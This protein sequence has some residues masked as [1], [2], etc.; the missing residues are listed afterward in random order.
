MS[1]RH[2]PAAHGTRC[3]R[4]AAGPFRRSRSSTYAWYYRPTVRRS[5]IRRFPSSRRPMRAAAVVLFVTAALAPLRAGAQAAWPD[6]PA[7]RQLAGWVAAFN[8]SSVDS[9][10]RFLADHAPGAPTDQPMLQVSPGTAGF[11]AQ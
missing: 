1:G 8:A 2:G 5:T 10:R 4:W 6:T 11:R 9:L 3:G 7:G